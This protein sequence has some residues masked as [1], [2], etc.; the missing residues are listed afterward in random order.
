MNPSFVFLQK[1]SDISEASF[2]KLQNISEVK[3]F[4][5]KEILAP[6]GEIPKKLYLLFSGVMRAYVSLECGKE[7]N[8]RL[9][10][11]ISFAGALTAIIKN[12]PSEINYQ[13]LTDCK[14]FEVDF[15]SFKK[16]C[17]E[18]FGIGKLYVRV[19]E[20]VFIAY[21]ERNLDLMILDASQLYSKLRKQIPNVDDLI[22]Q[23]QIAAYLGIT[24]VQLSRI[25]KKLR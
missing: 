7:Y 11:P 6:A 1:F 20:H 2:L 14:V 8:K 4:K 25:R 9:Y 24:P 12:E 17:R 23:Y 3:S 21:E 15:E 18:D 10:S 16:L 5:S 22:P 19:L 13:A